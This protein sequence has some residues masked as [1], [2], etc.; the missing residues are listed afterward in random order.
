MNDIIIKI[1]AHDNYYEKSMTNK[2]EY[3]IKYRGGHRL[4]IVEGKIEGHRIYGKLIPV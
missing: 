1:I 4:E 3:Y 2:E